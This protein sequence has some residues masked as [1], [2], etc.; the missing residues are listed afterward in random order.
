MCQ[1]GE[2]GDASRGVNSMQ[3]PAWVMILYSCLVCAREEASTSAARPEHR[4]STYINVAHR[5]AT[6]HAAF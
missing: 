6:E 5:A 1:A 3:L 2:E 4:C